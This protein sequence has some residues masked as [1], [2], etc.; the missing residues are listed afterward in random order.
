MNNKYLFSGNEKI[1]SSLVYG[2]YIWIA[3]NGIS[4]ICLLYQSSI[5]N[6]NSR[7]RDINIVANEI[8]NMVDDATRVFMSL[9]DVASMGARVYK[10]SE[11]IGY[12]EK[13]NTIVEKAIDL[14]VDSVYIYF[15][16]PGIQSGINS[17]IVK[18]DLYYS[19]LVEIID[20]TTVLNASKIDID[21]AGKLWVQSDLD[22]TPKITKVWYDTSWH[23]TTH[24]LS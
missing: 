4:N 11:Y 17:K 1:T 8:T 3:F 10:T 12:Y 5:F 15:L 21:S 22:G 23:F 20:L 24:V 19:T 7:Y 6:P 9:D 14:I 16:T 2:D 18:Y 13:N